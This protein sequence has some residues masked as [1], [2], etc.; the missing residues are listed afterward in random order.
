MTRILKF[1]LL[2][3]SAL[4][5]FRH[6]IASQNYIQKSCR[7]AIR[8]DQKSDG[9]ARNGFPLCACYRFVRTCVYL[10]SWQASPCCSQF[11]LPFL[12]SQPLIGCLSLFLVLDGGKATQS[13]QGT[14][15]RPRTSAWAE[16]LFLSLSLV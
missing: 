2:H 7:D 4:A 16:L 5:E 12:S 10:L 14:L 1:R 15:D 8:S 11:K 3:D 9:T 6:V 13:Q